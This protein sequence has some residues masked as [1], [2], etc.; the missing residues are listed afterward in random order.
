MILANIVLSERNLSSTFTVIWFYVYE[1]S[2]IG[3]P[4]DKDTDGV[5]MVIGC[6]GV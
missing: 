4:V 2:R 5:L 6:A 1:L 3:Q